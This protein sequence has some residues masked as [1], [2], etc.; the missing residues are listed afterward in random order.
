M[1]LESGEVRIEIL[2]NSKNR[3]VYVFACQ[4]PHEK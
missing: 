1:N 2:E 4:Y 3:H